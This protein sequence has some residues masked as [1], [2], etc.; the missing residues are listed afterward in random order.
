VPEGRMT[1][2]TSVP[3]RASPATIACI[4]ARRSSG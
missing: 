4:T 2:R 3:S 1:S